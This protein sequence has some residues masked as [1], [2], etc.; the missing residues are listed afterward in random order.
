MNEN[1]PDTNL[2]VV[3][4]GIKDLK[5]KNI[6]S[7]DLN[8]MHYWIIDKRMSAKFFFDDEEKYIAAYLRLS[9]ELV[10]QYL[11][12]SHPELLCENSQTL[13]PESSEQQAD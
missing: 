13:P 5:R 12:P 8:A 2:E 3:K 6:Q 4:Q 1:R 11:K 10:E 9:K 7:P